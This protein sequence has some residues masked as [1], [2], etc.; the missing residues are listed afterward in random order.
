M[1]DVPFHDVY[2]HQLVRDKYGRKMSKSLGNGIDPTEMVA[3][4]GTDPVRFTLAILA[5]QGRDL[6]LDIRFFDSYRK[7]ANKIWNA[8]RFVL[9]NIDDYFE[10]KY[11]SMFNTKLNSDQIYRIVKNTKSKFHFELEE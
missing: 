8:A 1:G 5:A 11:S 7:F 9:L 3:Q 2:I 10:N 6:K 4:Y